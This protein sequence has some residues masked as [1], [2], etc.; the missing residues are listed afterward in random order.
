M[1]SYKKNISDVNEVLELIRISNNSLFDKPKFKGYKLYFDKRFFV[2]WVEMN[3][4]EKV[5]IE[6]IL[7][8]EK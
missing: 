5:E 3:N 4:G 8:N 7:E 2:E 6:R 1:D